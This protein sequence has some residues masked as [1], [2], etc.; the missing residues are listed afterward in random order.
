MRLSLNKPDIHLS[1]VSTGRTNLLAS[2][3]LFYC[4]VLLHIIR[5]TRCMLKMIEMWIRISSPRVHESTSPVLVLYYASAN[6][7]MIIP[8]LLLDARHTRGTTMASKHLWPKYIRN[9]RVCRSVAVLL[10]KLCE[11]K[12]HSSIQRFRILFLKEVILVDMPF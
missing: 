7:V 8:K 10:C 9:W 6:C 3:N 11:W 5:L 1:F 4:C 2:W 12:Y